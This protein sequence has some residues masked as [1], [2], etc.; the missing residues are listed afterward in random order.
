M[1]S[2]RYWCGTKAKNEDEDSYLSNKRDMGQGVITHY[3]IA[4]LQTAIK[5]KGLQQEAF[6]YVSEYFLG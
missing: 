5:S 3:I 4:S 1:S 6:I 2:T